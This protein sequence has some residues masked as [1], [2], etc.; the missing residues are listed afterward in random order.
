MLTAK[1]QGVQ[2]DNY[3]L[4][5]EYVQLI[6]ENRSSA[7]TSV[8]LAELEQIRTKSAV[9]P[10]SKHGLETICGASCDTAAI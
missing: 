6:S 10:A 8:S 7:V 2:A 9:I 1:V 4:K 3:A 5:G